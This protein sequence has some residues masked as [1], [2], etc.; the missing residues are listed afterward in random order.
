M[1]LGKGDGHCSPLQANAE[2]AKTAPRIKEMEEGSIIV[3]DG[4][5]VDYQNLGPLLI[6]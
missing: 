5:T 3:R 4:E 2:V 6:S 1:L